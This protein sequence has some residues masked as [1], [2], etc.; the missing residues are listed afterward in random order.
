M[1]RKELVEYLAREILK[2][3]K[4]TPILVG[5]NGID[6]SGKT[7]LASEL[8]EELRQKNQKI[9]K[10]SIDDFHNP[11]AIRYKKGENSPEGYYYNSFNYLALI[12][13]LLSPLF[14]GKTECKTAVFD[15]RKDLE[16]AEPLI[17][18]ENNSIL[19]ME[20]VFLFRS[21][22]IK[23]WDLKIFLAI[24]FDSS[25]SRAINRESDKKYLGK[26]QAII[27]RYKN[28]YIQGQ[29]IYFKEENPLQKA[30]IVIDNNNY[31][32]PE[33]IKYL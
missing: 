8:A 27:E 18:I 3:K 6:A 21:E 32:A 28:K 19:L 31:L 10:A 15:Y 33:I 24:D 11:K 20:G 23:Y 2:I 7:F 4:T 25:I 30:D 1:E 14:L 16:L 29:K 17:Q 22:L 9:I 26:E 13:N 5:I 12:D